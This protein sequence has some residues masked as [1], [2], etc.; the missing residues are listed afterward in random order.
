MPGP[1]PPPTLPTDVLQISAQWGSAF[2]PDPRVHRVARAVFHFESTTV[3][4]PG[5][6]P[7]PTWNLPC[8]NWW[9]AVA[10]PMW[11]NTLLPGLLYCILQDTTNIH[12]NVHGAGPSLPYQGDYFQF[13][14][15]ACFIRRTAGTGRNWTGRCH[16][17]PIPQSFV[18]DQNYTPIALSILQNVATAMMATLTFDGFTFR[19]ILWSRQLGGTSPLTSV[20]LVSRPCQLARRYQFRKKQVLG[21]QYVLRP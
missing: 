9:D 3:I 10:Q 1:H 5:Y 13:A 15:S 8:F 20:E 17:L 12:I 4:P 19:P 14:Y 16:F 2:A 11:S 21:W 6:F 18:V 7:T